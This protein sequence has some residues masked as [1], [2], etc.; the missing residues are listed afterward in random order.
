MKVIGI[1]GNSGSGKSLATKEL[2][3]YNC[4]F[5]DLDALWTKIFSDVNCQNEVLEKVSDDILTDGKVDRKK[6]S[7]V[8]FADYKKLEILTEIT[9][10][11]IFK[12]TKKE[13]EEI[14]KTSNYDFIVLDGA[15][16]FDSLT[17]DL[18]DEVIL[19]DC[20]YN[21]KIER[22]M[23]RDGITYENATKRVNSQKDYKNYKREKHIIFNNGTKEEFLFELFDLVEKII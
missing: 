20:D 13:I 21:L 8:V 17:L 22:I 14:K 5:I 4:A 19:I 15:L 6:L 23:S 1:T 16:I 12:A 3:K 7:K 18:T 11:Y 9:D 2:K 10:R